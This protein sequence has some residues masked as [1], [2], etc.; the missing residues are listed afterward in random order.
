MQIKNFLPILILCFH[1][2]TH[3][4]EEIKVE[5]FDKAKWGILSGKEYLYRDNMLKD[6]MAN[7]R[8]TGLKRDTILKM[9]GYPNRSDTNYI[10]YMVRQTLVAGFFPLH[11]KT[12]VIEFAEDNTVRSAKIH[13]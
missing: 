10:F 13:E 9:L 2:C 12:L 1:A 8:L 7:K 4:K 11:T 5:K 3:Q 6:L